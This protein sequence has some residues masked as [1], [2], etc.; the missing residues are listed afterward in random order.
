MSTTVRTSSDG[1]T[2]EVAATWSSLEEEQAARLDPFGLD[3]P[4]TDVAREVREQARVDLLAETTTIDC[5]IDGVII[6]TGDEYLHADNIDL[7][8]PYLWLNASGE[9]HPQLAAELDHLLAEIG[10]ER[11]TEWVAP[12]LTT[13]SLTADTVEVAA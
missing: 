10:R 13:L 1:R 12:D 3:E 2:R 6:S 4:D 8:D 7:V 9:P 11:V 5:A